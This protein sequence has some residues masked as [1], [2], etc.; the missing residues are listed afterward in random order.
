MQFSRIKKNLF[1]FLQK[2]RGLISFCVMASA[3]LALGLF[4]ISFVSS[5]IFMAQDVD[6]ATQDLKINKRVYLQVTEKMRED[7]ERPISGIGGAR[8]PFY[9][10]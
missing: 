10:E 9:S 2:R 3:I 5:N 6:F 7:T 1:S 8:N 4:A